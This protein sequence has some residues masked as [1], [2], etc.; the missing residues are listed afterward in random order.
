MLLLSCGS[1][2]V[3]GGPL[4]VGTEESSSCAPLEGYEHAVWG[5]FVRNDS[6]Q[7]LEITRVVPTQSANVTILD[8]FLVAFEPSAGLLVQALPLNDDQLDA[9]DRR[10]DAQGATVP[11]GDRYWEVVIELEV[12]PGAEQGTV[13]ALEIGYRDGSGG[14]F[15]QTTQSAVQIGGQC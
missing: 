7:P 1:Q 8:T 10:V 11:P 5:T 15:V 2:P 14:E 3:H 9:W 4:W 12:E 6:D 13:D